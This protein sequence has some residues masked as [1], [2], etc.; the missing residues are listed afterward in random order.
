MTEPEAPN[1]DLSGG[2]QGL[3]SYPSGREPVAFS[4]ELRES[5]GWIEGGVRE[6]GQSG[7][8]AGLELNST[9]QGRRTGRSVTFLKLYDGSFRRY[10]TVRYEGEVSDDGAEISG[11]WTVPGS[12]SGSF[13]MIRTGEALKASGRRVAER[14]GAGR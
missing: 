9:L 11:A 10:D 13:L 5:G 2:W 7:E 8:A 6:V 12:W 14:L 1:L 4:A 3:Y